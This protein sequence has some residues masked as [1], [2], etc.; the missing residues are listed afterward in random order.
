MP[1]YY[2]RKQGSE[3]PKNEKDF[4]YLVYLE[5]PTANYIELDNEP[6][7][8]FLAHELNEKPLWNPDDEIIDVVD[9]NKVIL[10]SFKKIHEVKG[11]TIWKNNS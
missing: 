9:K 10:V 3:K 5:T 8:K 11:F 4:K 2:L 6:N 1:F 7:V